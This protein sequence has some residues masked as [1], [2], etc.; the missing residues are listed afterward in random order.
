M[1]VSQLAVGQDALRSNLAVDRVLPGTQGPPAEITPDEHH[2]GPVTF[3]PGVY[4][5]A[6]FNDNV[7][8][9]PTD[10][11]SDV[12]IRGGGT[13][14]VNW[15]VTPQSAITLG[16]RIGYRHYVEHHQYDALEIAPNSALT[17]NV[18]WDQGSL[19]FYDL[20][21]YSQDVVS[22]AALSGLASFPLLDNT[23][24]TR[25][26]LLPGKWLLEA[27]YSHNDY[28]SDSSGFQYLNRSSE[29]F[30]ARVGWRFA[31]QTQAGVEGSAS[32]TTYKQTLQRDS[33]SVSLGGF[34]DWQ[35]TRAISA[36]L[37][38]GPTYYTFYSAAGQPGS[39]L[40]GYYYSLEI[41]HQL[42]DFLS[43]RAAVRHEISLGYYPGSD[44][45]EQT[46]VSCDLSCALTHR[47]SAGLNLNYVQGNQPFQIFIFRF[48]ENFE[49]Y[50]IS[51]SA[52]WQLLDRLG[53]TM[54]YSHWARSSN[55]PE[56]G[57]AQNSI[58][59][60]LNYKF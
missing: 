10:A 38:G 20:F 3:S 9:V 51:P 16:A 52:T 14:D 23:V 39:T 44:Y 6:E 30:F 2:L 17:Y 33:R 58:F 24:G 59:L 57:Y 27:G 36:T 28:I 4:A 55:L 35:L 8:L 34:A 42:T 46:T 18:T 45:V 56:R 32:L 37:R 60:R 54:G 11:Q 48:T 31:E 12:I 21:S 13:L 1:L 7:N 26:S 19:A 5:G 40:N 41:D 22:Q 43:Y 50:G 25:L 47:L 15:S 29:Y 49:Q 53:L